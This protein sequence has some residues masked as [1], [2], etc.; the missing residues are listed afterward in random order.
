MR[1]GI[2]YIG[3]IIIV[4]MLGVSTTTFFYYSEMQKKMA[5]RYNEYSNDYILGVEG[6]NKFEDILN[7]K[8]RENIVELIKANEDRLKKSTRDWSKINDYIMYNSEE[9]VYRS[10]FTFKD[11]YYNKLMFVQM[12]ALVVGREYNIGYTINDKYEVRVEGKAYLD[13]FKTVVKVLNRETNQRIEL[14]GDIEVRNEDEEIKFRLGWRGDSGYFGSGVYARGD[15]IKEGSEIKVDGTNDNYVSNGSEE[16]EVRDVKIEGS[17]NII[18][19]RGGVVD[20]GTLEEGVNII[21]NESGEELKIVNSKNKVYDGIIYSVGDIVVEGY[22]GG[23]E[24]SII[25]GGNITFKDSNIDLK[26]GEDKIFSKFG[27]EEEN[28][29]ILDKVGITDFRS[30]EGYE[31]IDSEEINMLLGRSRIVGISEMN[32]RELKYEYNNIKEEE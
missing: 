27:N 32:L 10:Y 16:V 7:N 26:I 28:K 6:I 13:I 12:M 22:D 18:I 25:S 4:T 21:I 19:K 15:V 30:A 24:G 23:Y 14:R 17:E 5:I 3:V 8:M 20:I 2:S 1:E 31:V 29:R 9:E 11:N